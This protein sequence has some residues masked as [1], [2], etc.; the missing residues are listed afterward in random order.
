[1]VDP[2][3][4]DVRFRLEVIDDLGHATEVVPWEQDRLRRSLSCGLSSHHWSNPSWEGIVYS[5]TDSVY[6]LLWSH[7]FF[8]YP[9]LRYKKTQRRWVALKRDSTDN[10]PCSWMKKL[11]AKE[12]SS[13]VIN[14]IFGIS[15]SLFLLGREDRHKRVCDRLDVVMNIVWIDA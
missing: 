4:V 3:F 10:D 1:M 2:H 13:G 11:I 6:E 5:I 8:W 14:T 7:C 15:L 12:S 9:N